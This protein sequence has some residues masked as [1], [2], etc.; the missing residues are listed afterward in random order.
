MNKE[1]IQNGEIGIQEKLVG[2][3]NK[4][5]KR[6]ISRFI[7]SALSSIPW[8]GGFLS[9]SASLQAENDQSKVTEIQRLWL[10]EHQEKIEKLAETIYGIIKRLE[11]FDSKVEDRME[12]PE[13]QDLIKKGFRVWDNSDTDYKRDLIKNFM[14][15]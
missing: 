8:V 13:Y 2:I 6:R 4:N 9:A 15:R 5:N 10:L 14:Y 7:L 1:Q 11:S 12:S 3:L